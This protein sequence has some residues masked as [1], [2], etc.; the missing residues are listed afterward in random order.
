MSNLNYLG[1]S[2]KY[3]IAVSNGQ[4]VS[5]KDI[6][7]IKQS[8]VDILSTPLGSRYMQRNYGSRL[9]ESLFEPNN[10]ILAVILEND[11]VDALAI[12]EKR[13]TVERLSFDFKEAQVD[14]HIYFRINANGKFETFVYPFY[15]Q[16]II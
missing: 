15:R 5:V 12:W 7:L 16:N 3:P 10:K 11:I 8:I 2:I 4:I 13:I 9:S 1:K 14:C 6:E